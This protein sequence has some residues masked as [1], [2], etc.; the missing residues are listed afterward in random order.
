MEEKKEYQPNVREITYSR[1]DESYLNYDLAALTKML[2][3]QKLKNEKVTPKI[4]TE[5]TKIQQEFDKIMENEK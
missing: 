5:L 1:D 2:Q 3:D 4:D